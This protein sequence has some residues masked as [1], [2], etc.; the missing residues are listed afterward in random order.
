[1]ELFS[2]LPWLHIQGNSFTSMQK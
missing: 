1:M 2:F